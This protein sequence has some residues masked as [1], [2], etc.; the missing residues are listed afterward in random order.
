[1]LAPARL[2]LTSTDAEYNNDHED[3]Q[4]RGAYYEYDNLRSLILGGRKGGGSS[5]KR[6]RR[7]FC[8]GLP[9]IPGVTRGIGGYKSL[10]EPEVEM[11]KDVA[12]G[13]EADVV[14]TAPSSP[15]ELT[16]SKS[17]KS[18]NS[19]PSNSLAG[20]ISTETLSHFEDIT[21]DEQGRSSVE[22]CN[23][24]PESRPTLRRPLKRAS[25]ASAD[26]VRSDA[27]PP[28]ASR[29]TRYPSL[30]G[31][32]N[33]V[34]RDQSLNLPQARGMRYG[35]TSPLSPSFRLNG[36]R[37]LSSRSPSPRKPITHR[38]ASYSPQLVA[39]TTPRTSWSGPPAVPNSMLGRRQS[40][41]PGRK[42]AKQLEAEYDDGDDELPDD[43]VLENVPIT[44][45]PGQTRSPRVKTPSPQR[46]PLHNTL[47][48][49]NVPKNAKRPSA[50]TVMP[51]GQYGAP[52]S[53]RHGRP[54]IL[55]HSATT[56][57]FPPEA[58]S[59]KHRSKS[60]ASDLNE[61]ARELS[62]A[63]E[64]HAERLSSDKRRSGTSSAASSPPRPGLLTKRAKTAVVELPPI[65]KGSSLIDPL[66]ISKEKEAVLTRTRP[67]WLPPKNQK[68]EK[69]H[70]K[71]WERMMTHAADADKRRAVKLQEQAST[72]DSH[73]TNTA[74]I[75][76]DHILPNWSTALPDPQT[77]A[78]Y[79]RGIPPE[80]RARVW[81]RAVGNPL[82]L[83]H[84][85]FA[86]A[87]ARAD[88]LSRQLADLPSED[89]S[90]SREAAWFAAIERDAGT[91]FH[92]DAELAEVF[93]L[94]S[95]VHRALVEVLRAYAVYRPDVGY[96]F[97][98]HLVAATLCLYMRA[99]EAFV[100]LAN[101]LNR[102]VPL[103]FLV[104]DKAAMAAVYERVLGGLKSRCEGL[105]AHLSSPTMDLKAEEYLDPIFRCL[106]AYNLPAGH[107]SRLWDVYVF[108]GDEVLIRA[109]VAVL[110]RLEGKLYG[111][112]EEVLDLL[113][114]RNRGRWEVGGE[115]EFVGAVGEV[116]RG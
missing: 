101:L 27:S 19:S 40:W 85:T 68:E 38:D 20:D 46:K 91:A 84:A 99:G 37:G 31:A 62:A 81:S 70:V 10:T 21:L 8:A 73:Q 25:T 77:Q 59:L 113:S 79:H 58:F 71:E 13:E 57:S 44:P 97:S 12:G 29:E 36:P 7:V 110:G 88:A 94:G 22:D 34:L 5:N 2:P 24:K 100:V 106:F 102:P 92:G 111:G 51:N 80:C 3:S 74:Q 23:V 69:K 53:P 63:L 108:E 9:D 54:P 93:H 18:S 17:S 83:S 89:R 35:S 4:Q 75:W 116:G 56:T 76:T 109:A 65:R 26:T 28:N 15:P 104:H 11:E 66:P 105:H 82:Q 98:T 86:T 30:Q 87:L 61:E 42:T 90:A 67:S 16:Y 55:P 39:S 52:R 114:W 49:A 96:V 50:P 64:E 6:T 41:Q 78:L 32:V 103:A 107:V 72:K 60:W 112:K 14:E 47:H 45:L 115:E 48:S 33:G 1:M 43:A 95:P